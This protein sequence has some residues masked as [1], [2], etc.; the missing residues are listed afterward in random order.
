MWLKCKRHTEARVNVAGVNVIGLL[1]HSD[2]VRHVAWPVTATIPC[3]GIGKWCLLPVIFRVYS[4]YIC[5]RISDGS[6]QNA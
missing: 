5:R 4:M 6:M 1:A 2:L 3:T